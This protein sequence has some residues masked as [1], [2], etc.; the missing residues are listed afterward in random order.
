MVAV[1]FCAARGRLKVVEEGVAAAELDDDVDVAAI[2]WLAE[3]LRLHTGQ[4]TAML[5][6]LVERGD[7]QWFMGRVSMLRAQKLLNKDWKI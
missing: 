5:L 1:E 3:F 2:G 7:S 6:S 4:T